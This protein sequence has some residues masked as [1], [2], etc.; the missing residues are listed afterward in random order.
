VKVGYLL[1]H[2]VSVVDI[3]LDVSS[4]SGSVKVDSCTV[5]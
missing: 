3:A 2:P 5:P 4:E 1:Y